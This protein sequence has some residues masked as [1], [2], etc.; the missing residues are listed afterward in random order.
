M[1]EGSGGRGGKWKQER[2]VERKVER[3]GG[4]GSWREVWEGV[5]LAK[6]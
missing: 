4:G 6:R 1:K 3:E 2:K 5:F